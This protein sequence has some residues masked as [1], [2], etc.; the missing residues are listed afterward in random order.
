[1]LLYG[2]M[3]AN[4]K[5]PE[6]DIEYLETFDIEALVNYTWSYY[7]ENDLDKSWHF[8][9]DD[10]KKGDLPTRKT[11]FTCKRHFKEKVL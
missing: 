9:V 10:I 11:T 5:Y 8:F 3:E 7:Y 2:L 4:G 1:M 6:Y